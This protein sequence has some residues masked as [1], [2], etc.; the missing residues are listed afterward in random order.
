MDLVYGTPVLA[1]IEFKYPREPTEK[2]LPWTMVLGHILKDLYRLSL[3]PHG[4]RVFALLE[5]DRLRRYLA[6]AASSYGID[7][8][9]D[10]VVL[11]PHA[12]ALLPATASAVIGPDL[13][14]R[15]VTA[16]RLCHL[17]V[18]PSAQL[19]VYLVDGPTETATE[20]APSALHHEPAAAPPH[21]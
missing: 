12:A 3:L 7:L 2:N 9:R 15:R 5:T 4:D 8:D 14:R 13:L 16:A 1:A 20:A 19:S 10:A 17:P 11:D 6:G 21:G 18:G